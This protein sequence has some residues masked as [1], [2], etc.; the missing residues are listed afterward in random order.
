MDE[1]EKRTA[2]LV[3]RSL[4][5]V[6]DFA[7]LVAAAGLARTGQTRPE[8]VACAILHGLEV[9]LTPLQALQGVTVING[10]AGLDGDAALALV[11]ASGLC[12]EWTERMEG[13]GDAR[14]AVVCSARAGQ[15]RREHAFS[16]LDAKRAG[17]WTKPGPW[18]Q[19]PE[20]MLRYRALGFHVRDVYPDVV[21][22]LVT[23]EELRDYPRRVEAVVTDAAER[24]AIQ[25]VERDEE[26]E[27]TRGGHDGDRA[28]EPGAGAG[29]AVSLPGVA[30]GYVG[31]AEHDEPP[32]SALAPAPGPGASDAGPG[33]V[34]GAGGDVDPDRVRRIEA[35]RRF[36]E[37][38]DV[39][40]LPPARWGQAVEG[41]FVG[42]GRATWED[43]CALRVEVPRLLAAYRALLGAIESTRTDP[44]PASE[45]Q[46]AASAA[47]A[48]EGVPA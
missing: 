25:A 15:S 12:V 17:L 39:S 44:G 35:C 27:A 42:L 40:G 21:R 10:R 30:F 41:A 29:A 43:V 34:P 19:Y 5:E 37:R 45:A 31:H 47:D 20:R 38:L 22:G 14:R 28:D 36:R 26:Q 48:A 18:S 23:A 4:A 11:M 9:G 1:I 16:V 3:P 2:A 13:E 33:P 32:P 8:Q 24:A 7:R 46:I 6:M